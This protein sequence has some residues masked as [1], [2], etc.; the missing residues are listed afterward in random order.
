MTT[1]DYIALI[2]NEHRGRPNYAAALRAILDPI[3]G[4]VAVA[5]M[6]QTLF[7]IDTATGN[8]LDAV[9]QWIGVTRT[10]SVPL[11]NVYFS[12]NEAGLGFNQGTWFTSGEPVG[13]LV[14]LPDQQ[15]RLLLKA[16]ALNNHW[17]GSLQGAFDILTA[18]FALSD[19]IGYIIDNGDLTMYLGIVGK[20]LDAITEAI[21]AA[22]L[23]D[24][25]PAG[26][27]IVDRTTPTHNP[28]VFALDP[29]PRQTAYAGL[30][31]GSWAA[32]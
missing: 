9:G 3:A 16:R 7:D 21:F 31:I 25:R 12:F 30:D 10:L 11:S 8:A 17:D 19:N 13:S 18:L 24:V 28:P 5:T 20:P 15:Y 27:S 29:A 32:L 14:Q 23:L 22:G 4:T 2:T 1:D 6:L 26:V